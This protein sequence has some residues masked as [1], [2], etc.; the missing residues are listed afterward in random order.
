[1]NLATEEILKILTETNLAQGWQIPLAVSRY[2]AEILAANLDK[3][4]WQ[5]SPSYAERYMTIRRWQDYLELG[6][7]CWFTRAVFPEFGER[8]GINSSYY[9]QMGEACWSQALQHVEQPALELM[10]RHFEFLAETAY[11]AIRCYGDF[12]SMWD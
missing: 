1:M 5:P 6:N 4:P 3:N 8:R 9:V 2:Q 11:T 10:T 12:R 7:T